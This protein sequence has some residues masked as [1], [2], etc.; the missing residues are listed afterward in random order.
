MTTTRTA[1]PVRSTADLSAMG[2]DMDDTMTVALLGVLFSRPRHA[3][4]PATNDYSGPACRHAADAGCA[5]TLVYS[6]AH[7]DVDAYYP[8]CVNY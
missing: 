7:A 3:G 6:A 4:A 2:Y 8:G 1:S 5:G